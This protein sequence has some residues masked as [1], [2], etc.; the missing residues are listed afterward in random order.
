MCTLSI[1]GNI[2]YNFNDTAYDIYVQ[3]LILI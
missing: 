2:I 1:Y 3:L